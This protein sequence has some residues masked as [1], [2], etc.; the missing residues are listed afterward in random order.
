MIMILMTFLMGQF[1]ELGVTGLLKAYYIKRYD[2]PGESRP[3]RDE[4]W[5]PKSSLGQRI[6][7]GFWKWFLILFAILTLV[8]A[9]MRP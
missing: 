9:F 3:A 5:E 8:A 1:M 6:W 7:F 2:I 4:R